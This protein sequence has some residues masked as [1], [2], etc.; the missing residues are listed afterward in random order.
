MSGYAAYRQPQSGVNYAQLMQ[1][2]AM[3]QAM[4]QQQAQPQEAKAP[5][6]SGI[7]DLLSSF[8]GGGA[9]GAAA[10]SMMGGGAG[11]VPGTQ[12]ADVMSLGQT[13]PSVGPTVGNAA[14]IPAADTIGLSGMGAGPIAL[15][16]LGAGYYLSNIYE[17]GGKDII[18]GKGKGSDYANL[19]LDVNPVTAPI[20]I[21]L[22]LFG[23]KSLGKSLFGH[24][25]TG[26]RQKD[27]WKELAKS[28]KAPEFFTSS[29]VNQDQGIDDNKLASGKL[30]GKDVWASSVFFNKF[31]K[32]DGQTWD[33]TGTE[34]QREQIANEIL[35]NKLLDTR[36]GLTRFT[37]ENAVQGIYDKVLG[38]KTPPPPA[39]AAPQ[40]KGAA[41][42]PSMQ[43]L[44][45]LQT[46]R[47]DSPGF[48]DGKRINLWQR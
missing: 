13:M 31:S 29:G 20:N 10:N 44:N 5:S 8:G 17:G 7:S 46:L 32:P 24:Q 16:A 25:S 18:R 45:N 33:R 47:K 15:G 19:M 26:D 27:A 3:K 2:L 22:R 30:G 6:T 39:N 35:S 38:N 41:P 34:A 11:A 37:D 23:Q 14:A 9:G 21:G 12:L 40:V 48:K 42:L 36:K 1:M 4:E 43:D 28:G